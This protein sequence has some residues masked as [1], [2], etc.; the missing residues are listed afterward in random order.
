MGD[1]GRLVINIPENKEFLELLKSTFWKAGYCEQVI[2]YMNVGASDFFMSGK[3]LY[4]KSPD[5]TLQVHDAFPVDSLFN[6]FIQEY[7]VV[8]IEDFF[9]QNDRD[10]WLK[11]TANEGIQV[12][13]DNLRVT[14][15]KQIT[16]AVF[17]KSC[18]C[19]LLKVN[20][21]S[22]V[23]KFLQRTQSNVWGM[24]VY[25]LSEETDCFHC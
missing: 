8:S 6:F 25:H 14:K 10:A 13:G 7:A 3:Y 12:V 16:K 5:A 1:K 11:F 20:Q 9:D 2:I 21:I 18:N 22:L 17:E 19:L 23:T 15:P 4:F 24:M